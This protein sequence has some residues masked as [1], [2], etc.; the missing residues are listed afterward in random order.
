MN[1][2]PNCGVAVED[3]QRFCGECGAKLVFDPLPQEPV[4]TD[5]ERLKNDPKLRS[6]DPA[7]NGR[8]KSEKVPELTL[9]PDVWGMGAAAAAQP[10]P[11]PAQD[12]GTV[13][14]AGQ[15]EDPSFVHAAE[16]FDYERPDAEYHGPA[17]GSHGDYRAPR[18]ANELPRDYTMSGAASRSGGT[19]KKQRNDT[20]M[21]A[22]AIILTSL[23]SVCGIVGL[24]KV[25]KARRQSDAALRTKLLNSAETWLIVGTILRLLTFFGNLL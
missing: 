5:S 21:L 15:R 16:D 17:Q 13:V 8:K 3:G 24:V 9:E 1:H 23:F 6:A 19:E 2:C 4:Y 20:L 18:E 25:I 14:P 10:A 12:A 7:P 11:D 22:W